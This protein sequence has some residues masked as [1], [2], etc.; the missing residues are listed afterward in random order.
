MGVNFNSSSAVTEGIFLDGDYCLDH[1]SI[2]IPVHP[3]QYRAIGVIQGIYEPLENTL[4]KGIITTADN[5]TFETVLLGKTISAVK[6]HVDLNEVQN[7]VVYPHIVPELDRI[8][9]QVAGIFVVNNTN[10][11]YLPPNYFSIRGEVI[12][13]SK[14]EQKVIVKIC[15]NDSLSSKRISFFKLELTGKIPDHTIKHF[16]SFSVFLEGQKLI[17]KKY[18]DLGLI[19]VNF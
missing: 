9:L 6:N 18:I 5:S 13:S 15:K 14:K 2:G 4:T 19:A 8:H 16:Y 3:L 7:W 11:N 17:I 1:S 12:Y 10:N